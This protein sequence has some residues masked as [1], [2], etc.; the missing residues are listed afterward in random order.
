MNQFD[1][2][3][4]LEKWLGNNGID[5]AQWGANGTK[6]VQDLWEE[7][8]NGDAQLQLDPPLRQ[9]YVTEV[10][11]QDANRI[12]IELEQE[13]GS[14]DRRV[15]RR[16]PSEKMHEDET[17]Q[18]AALRCLAEELGVSAG[19][20]AFLSD[21]YKRATQTKNSPSYPGLPTRYVFYR[22]EV[23]VQG[24]PAGDFWRDNQAFGHGDPVRRHHWG[25]IERE[26]YEE[27]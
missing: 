6:S 2:V 22:I 4:E 24:L 5:T 7:L 26:E 3:H 9:V 20:V 15:R 8:V 11:I 10:M 23:A 27:E 16:V 18:T 19:R 14:G 25:W 17:S 1:T 21:A 12:L 13:F